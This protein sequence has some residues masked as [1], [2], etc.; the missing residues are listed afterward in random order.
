MTAVKLEGIRKTYGNQI[1]L[2][3][4]SLEIHETVIF[5]LIGPNGAG[6]TT[7]IR[8]I[9]GLSRPDSGSVSVFGQDV[10]GNRLNAAKRVTAQ[11]QGGAVFNMLT[12]EENLRFFAAARG[13]QPDL[14]LV[15]ELGLGKKRHVLVSRLSGGQRQRVGLAVALQS[16]SSLVIL[17]EPTAGLDP[18]IRVAVWDI[19]HRYREKGGTV[20]VTTHYLEEVERVCDVVGII[21]NGKVIAQ[22]P[23]SELIGMYVTDTAI[24]FR[25]DR[26]LVD[27]N[28]DTGLSGVTRLV[29]T[30]D[31]VILYTRNVQST[32]SELLALLGEKRASLAGLRLKHASLEDV[33]L[34]LTRVSAKEAGDS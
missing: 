9:L 7:A 23:P 12:V 2:D 27:F 13:V 5:G 31:R 26:H 29:R 28:L 1:A 16:P 19:V 32:L 21:S 8:V 10:V 11:L 30:S 33:Y 20:L 34:A 25:A 6:K 18:E 24:E 3:G 4:L 14:S 22:G 15:D 17:D